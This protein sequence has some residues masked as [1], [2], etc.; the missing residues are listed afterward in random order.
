LRSV[1]ESYRGRNVRVFRLD[2][3]AVL[4]RLEERARRLLDEEPRVKEVWLFGSL[5]RGQAGPG[6]D[7]DLF[8]VLESST[9]SFVDRSGL[10]A[11]HFEG[12][13][14]GCDV[15]AYT[16]AELQSLRQEGA[17]LPRTVEAE[18]RLLAR[19]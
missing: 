11:R 2:S 18:G 12:S 15:L 19:R 1:E 10:L 3:G 17:A 16:V 4:A 13:G 14:V 9:L 5:A 6:S 7:A 8:V